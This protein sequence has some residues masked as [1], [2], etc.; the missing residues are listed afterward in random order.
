MKDNA[1][2]KFNKDN[3]GNV[4]AMLLDGIRGSSAKTRR[5]LSAT[6]ANATH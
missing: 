1:P 2:V 5:R 6:N 3:F 4:R